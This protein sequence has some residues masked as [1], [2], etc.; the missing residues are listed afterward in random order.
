MKTI[1]FKNN[2][3]LEAIEAAGIKM[4]CNEDMNIV[5][6]NKDYERLKAEFTAAYQDSYEVI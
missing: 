5:I 6:S 2:V 3:D 4:Y 1:N